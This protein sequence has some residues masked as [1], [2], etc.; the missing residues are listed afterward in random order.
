MVLMA[1]TANAK[2]SE[3]VAALV[4][5]ILLHA[6]AFAILLYHRWPMQPAS[7]PSGALTVVSLSA[8]PA[9]PVPRPIP[10]PIMPAKIRELVEEVAAEQVSQETGEAAV[11]TPGPGCTTLEL[12]RNAILADP[13]AVQ[14]VLNAPPETRSIAEAVVLW[15]AGWSDSAGSPESPLMPTRTAVEKSL[16]SVEQH[17]LDET[18]AGPRLVPIPAGTGT[19]FVVF[20]S[21]TWT[22]RDVIEE[23]P[24]L[25]Q[26]G[27]ADF[28]GQAVPSQILRN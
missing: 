20:G 4:A 26:K 8:A 25:E 28:R 16:G 10:P 3:R 18:I 22:W 9:A 13:A 23:S 7:Q 1:Q 15:N 17:C 27:L 5:V 14:S 2:P 11:G 12:V 21:D 6:I 24:P 19:M